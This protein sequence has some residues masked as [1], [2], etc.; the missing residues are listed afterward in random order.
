MLNNNIH[1]SGKFVGGDVEARGVGMD[2]RISKCLLQLIS[3]GGEHFSVSYK[4]PYHLQPNLAPHLSTSWHP[5][6]QLTP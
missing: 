4:H 2:S 3:F 5:C 1:N 6:T